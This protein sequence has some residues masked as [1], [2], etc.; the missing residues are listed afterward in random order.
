M[1][2]S[3][4][5][6][7]AFFV[8]L[9][10][11]L[12]GSTVL[13]KQRSAQAETGFAVKKPVIAA[14]GRLAPWGAIAE[15]FREAIRP[16]GWDVQICYNCAGGPEE[17]RFVFEARMPP[18]LPDNRVDELGPPPQ[19]PVDL[20]VTTPNFLWWAY[21]GTNHFVDAGPQRD[22]R[23]IA[24][25]QNPMYLFV[26]ARAEL[27]IGDLS[28]IKEKRWPVRILW[29]DGER[30]LTHSGREILNYYGLSQESIEA[31]GGQLGT[32]FSPEI[33]ETFDIFIMCR[34]CF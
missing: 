15:I 9:V 11:L 30:A 2:A 5:R 4:C 10:I 8:A 16:Y 3:H 24:L 31:A 20:G 28:Q 29:D 26:G 6:F 18:A 23:L 33:R 22:L 14:S 25:I 21:Q 12:G 13:A 17:A 27:G 7:A 32:R 19:G 1:P 34:W